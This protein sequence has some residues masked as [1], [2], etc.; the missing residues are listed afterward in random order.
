MWPA[1]C[2][3]AARRTCRRPGGGPVTAEELPAEE[4]LLANQPPLSPTILGLFRGRPWEAPCDGSETP[5]RSV[6]LYGATWRGNF[7]R[8]PS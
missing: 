6:V 5:C 1:P 7:A 4:D 2:G 8:P 3:Q